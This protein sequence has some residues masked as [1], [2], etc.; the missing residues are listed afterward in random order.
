LAT[1]RPMVSSL[2]G[3]GE[4]LEMEHGDDGGDEYL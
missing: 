4:G 2:G 1:E 3:D